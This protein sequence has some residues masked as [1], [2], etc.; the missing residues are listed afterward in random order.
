MYL[1]ALM[2]MAVSSEA[3]RVVRKLGRRA[4]LWDDAL[5]AA[6]Q[7]TAVM[8]WRSWRPALREAAERRLEV[9]FCPQDRREPQRWERDRV[10]RVVYIVVI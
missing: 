3:V 10:V 2:W 9:I 6:E 4:V 8:L 1:L 7:G 5:G